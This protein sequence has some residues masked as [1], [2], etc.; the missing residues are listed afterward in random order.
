MARVRLVCGSCEARVWL[1]CGSREAR[2]WLVC[3]SRVAPCGP[4]MLG[5]CPARSESA[6]AL[7]LQPRLAALCLCIT[8]GCSH[9]ALNF[10]LLYSS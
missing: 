5:G 4:V 6:S 2:V 7:A 8:A 3:G 1:V 9:S 10:S